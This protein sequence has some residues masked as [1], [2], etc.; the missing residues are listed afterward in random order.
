MMN[1]RVR[2]VGVVFALIAV[3]AWA[4][5]GSCGK[6]EKSANTGISQGGSHKHAELGHPA[7]D[8]TLPGVDGK[9]YKLSDFKGKVIV[10]EWT[11]HNCPFVKRHQGEKKTM[12]RTFAKFNG[13]PVAWL[14]ID[15]SHYCTEQK[16]GIQSWVKSQDIAYP[17][18]LDPTGKVGHLYSA[19][20]TPHVFVIDQ[21][22]T[23]AY[24]GAI[25]DDEYG[26]KAN[27]RNYVEEAVNALLTGSTVAVASTKSYG[28]SVKYKK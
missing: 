4:H 19:K 24:S 11:N 20:T 22:G 7:P 17:I 23:L 27:V 15:S 2:L 18:L 10:L 16:D 25:D 21:K 12:Q 1:G 9:E 8:F 13:K 5:C 28:C 3:P 14:A 6:G 26:D